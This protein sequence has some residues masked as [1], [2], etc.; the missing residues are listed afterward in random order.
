MSE[1]QNDE[2]R[3]EPLR[4][5]GTTWVDRGG[6]YWARRAAVAL[7]SLAAAA[8]GAYVLRLAYEGLDIAETGSLIRTLMVVAFAV[9]SSLA[10]TR[11]LNGFRRPHE[12]G[13][14]DSSWRAI[15][16]VG[17]VGVLVAWFL[18]SL[19]EAPGEKLARAGYDRE[20]ELYERRRTSRTGNPAKKGARK[21]RKKR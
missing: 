4:F 5:F 3:P 11:T 6:G 13:E 18:R 1:Q 7:G 2:P 12:P 14:A 8:A 20:R 10:L 17:F 9:C 15:K 19:A 16:V 21:R